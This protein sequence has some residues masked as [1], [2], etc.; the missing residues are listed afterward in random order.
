[1]RYSKRRTAA[2][3]ENNQAAG[4]NSRVSVLARYQWLAMDS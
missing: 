4:A 2:T 3:A 1:M